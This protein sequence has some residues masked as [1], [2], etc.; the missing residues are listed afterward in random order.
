[1]NNALKIWKGKEKVMNYNM[2][3]E[4]ETRNWQ[5]FFFFFL[6]NLLNKRVGVYFMPQQNSRT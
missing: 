4:P 3:K 1:M 6:R 5:E 2:L